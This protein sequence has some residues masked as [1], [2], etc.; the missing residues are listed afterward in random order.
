MKIC[1]ICLKDIT[2][3]QKYEGYH[4]ACITT[5]LGELQI[6]PHLAFDKSI[7]R[8][9]LSQKYIQGM[10]MSGVQKKLSLK[11]EE[12]KLVATQKGGMFILKPSVD[13]FPEVSA[14]EHLTMRLGEL[15]GIVTPPCGLIKFKDFELAYLIKRFDW[16]NGEEKFLKEDMAQIF[17]LVRDEGQTYKYSMSYEEVGVKLLE[18]TGN[19]LAEV[20][21]FF[22]RVL[23]AFLSGN[24]DLHLKNISVYNSKFG[25]DGIFDGLT[26]NY[27]SVMTKLYFPNERDMALELLKDGEAS[28]EFDD[29]GFLTRVDFDLLGKRIGLSD[30]A[31][32]IAF[33]E[34]SRRINTAIELIGR[35]F[36]SAPMKQKYLET[37]NSRAKKLDLIK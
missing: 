16:L 10:S 36:L 6:S 2:G 17:Q 28:P 15:F 25:S 5:L 4:N 31:R 21:Q 8:A 35:S 32:E 14:N 34:M 1:H 12:R 11:V 13:D 18:L 19:K 26:P 37:F 9:E 24:G 33:Y 23:F 7:F 22:R 20:F 30:A 27:D 3:E 29:T